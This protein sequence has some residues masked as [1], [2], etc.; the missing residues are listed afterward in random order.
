MTAGVANLKWDESTS[1]REVLLANN[2]SMFRQLFE[3][4]ADA[5]FL[6]D[7]QREIFV[8]CNQAAVAMMRATNKQQL[9]MKNPAELSVEFQPD[10]RDSRER[11]HEDTAIALNRGSHR[12]EWWARRMDGEEFPVDVML[13]PIQ[14]GEHTLIAA[15][16]RDITNRKKAERELLEMTQ[17]LEQRVDERT[18]ELSASEARLRA[19]VEHAPEA[20]VVFDGLTGRIRFGNEHAC[21]LYGV[22]M[23]RL[24]EL[25]PADVS[26]E[27]Q[28]GG[29]L[30]SELAREKMDE[31]LRGGI[32]VFEWIH[33]QQPNG[34]LIPTEVRLLRLP[35][36]SQNLIRAS[37]IDNTERKQ[38]ERALRESE[39]KFRALFEG[40]SQGVVLH[41]EHGLL[42]VN[43]AAV[44]ILGRKSQQELLGKHPRELAPPLQPN[45]ESSEAMAAK[46][47]EQCL[48]TGSARFD[49]LACDP[50]GK[51]IPMEV[52]LTRIEWS[53]RQVI[54]AFITDITER[55]Q[56]ERALREANRELHREIEQRIR[57]EESLKERVR[58]STLNAEVAVALNAGNE[59]QPMLQHCSEL[60]VQHLDVAFARIWT[61][62]TETQTLELQASAGCYTHLDGPHSRVKVG[63]YKIGWIAQE[64]KP[65]LTNH[66]QSDARISDQA[67]AAREGMVAFAGYPLLLEGRVLGVLAMFARH[68]LADDVLNTLD[69]IAHSLALGI[70]RKRAQTALVESEAR[71]SAAF[72]A[73]PIIISISRVSD[74]QYVLVNDA[75]VSWSGYS[76]D[77]ILGRNAQELELWGDQQERQDFWDGLHRT[78]SIRE[79]EWRFRNRAGKNF[80]MLVSCELIQLNHVPHI[81][82]MAHDITERKQAE[83][84][85]RAS[86][87]RL[88][89]S[90]ARFS[91]AFQASPALIGIF[92]A[93]DGKY[94]LMNDA[95]LN[96][97]GHPREEVLGHTCLELGVWEKPDDR[98]L[99]LKELQT[100]GSIRQRECRWRNRRGGHFTVLLSIEPIKVNDTPHM[101]SMAVDITERKRAEE[102][103]RE[104]EAQLRES[105]ARFS[106]A[107][108][109]SPVFI[110][111]FRVS[112]QRF[113]LVNDALVSWMGCSREEMLGRTTVELEMWQD[114][115]DRDQVWKELRE[116]GSIRQRECRLC[117]RHG[118]PFTILLSA[119]TIRLNNTPHIL[120]LAQ[121]I[122]QRKRAEEELVKTLE[123]EKELSQL[124]SNFV[125]MVSHEFRTPLGIIQSSAEL[126][127]D[128]HGRMPPD[129][130]SEQLDSI[131]R[132][133]RRMAGMMEEVL[134]LSRLDAGKLSFRPAPLDL[135]TF[136]RLIVDEV[137]SATNRRCSIELS[138]VSIPSEAQADEQLLGHIFTNLLSN[139][140]K[141][142]E[143]GTAVHFFVSQKGQ[144]VVC[145]I[146]DKGI[147]IPEEDQPQLFKAFH[148]GRNVGTRPG[149]GLGLLLVKRCADLHGGKV[150]VESK[151]G[152]GTTAT[153]RLPVFGT[154]HEKNTGH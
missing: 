1:A 94:V 148:R 19:L 116:V 26:P 27:F 97:L 109:A 7:P 124:K 2:E 117:N 105:E 122:T 89:E 62:N 8:D 139:A 51:D 18:A 61:L 110:S 22:P 88:R 12:Y 70:E 125:S 28:P 128:F 74:G 115:A 107:F 65:L 86:E 64:K 34:R 90:E 6:S 108:Q 136:F 77:E 134:V 37:I 82:G 130:R 44:R 58:M 95:F 150:Q 123:R 80:V 101:L 24:T 96:W 93:N 46:Y 45:G 99:V 120:S 149:T 54:Q 14:N 31:A 84:V 47:I 79:R 91:V 50:N 32:L 138:I 29:R 3:H 102:K 106:V 76:R 121:D 113:V 146:R 36:E 129:E 57:A 100:L 103:L 53:G 153:V 141:Y 56:A 78:G 147:G 118:E 9:L 21:R 66:V 126:L 81:L 15:V 132:N 67:W 20:I 73:S 48:A 17:V 112:D 143:A 151:I 152:D 98:D 111:I 4:S 55:K 72:Q 145:V 135:N 49:W 41:D 92:R 131:S 30:S 60:M 33:R 137:L 43:S 52:A 11:V 75:F 23:E 40:S 39:A 10:G 5:M 25:T 83:A 127:R 42:E 71:F 59:L 68:P 140:V 144:D 119:E 16:C 87:A 69:S 63:Q 133:A 114:N 38:A 85:Q 13:T 104:S 35:S 142:S 154:S